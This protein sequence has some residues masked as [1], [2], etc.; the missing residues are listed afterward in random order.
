MALLDSVDARRTGVFLDMTSSGS[1]S[2]KPAFNVVVTVFE[3]TPPWC[4]CSSR[5]MGCFERSRRHFLPQREGLLVTKLVTAMGASGC[6]RGRN[7]FPN[8]SARQ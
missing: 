6:R 4:N 2:N 5:T 8:P 3:L 1:S 7:H